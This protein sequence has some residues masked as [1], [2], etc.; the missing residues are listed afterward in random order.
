[1]PLV[2]TFRNLLLKKEQ[3]EAFWYFVHVS[4]V[5]ALVSCPQP[6]KANKESGKHPT[7]LRAAQAKDYGYEHFGLEEKELGP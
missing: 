6:G 1:M 3:T 5:A 2:A 7:G 4:S